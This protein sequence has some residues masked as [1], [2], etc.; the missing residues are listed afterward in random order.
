MADAEREPTSEKNVGEALGV[1]LGFVLLL[2]A[3]FVGAVVLYRIYPDHV[4]DSADPG[5]IDNVFDN[6]M[7]VFAARSV[8][9]SFALV[10]AFV[11]LFVIASVIKWWRAGEYLT[12]AAGFEV[13]QRAVSDLEQAAEYWQQNALALGEQV[14]ELSQRLE[15]SDALF[16]S[17]LED[18]DDDDDDE[19]DEETPDDD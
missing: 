3:P 19:E 8:L 5:F 16:A 7:V 10:L 15:A 13:S 17:L 4:V 14:Q 18:D 6:N 12:R 9:L 1:A 11:G 2:L